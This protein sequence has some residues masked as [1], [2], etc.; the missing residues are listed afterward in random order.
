MQQ[1]AKE[2]RGGDTRGINSCRA[3]AGQHADEA[4]D[5]RGDKSR[6]RAIGEI[7]VAKRH[8]GEHAESHRERNGNGRGDETCCD[9]GLYRCRVQERFRQRLRHGV[10]SYSAAA[11]IR[12]GNA[13][14]SAARSAFK[15]PRS[16]ISP[17][18]SRAGVTSKA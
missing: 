15:T 9:F 12:S 11:A 1:K 5:D 18:T 13:E 10:R 17:V 14:E 8:K 3:I 7:L 2:E 6:H 4:G 16:V